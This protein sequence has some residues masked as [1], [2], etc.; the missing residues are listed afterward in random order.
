MIVRYVIAR[1]GDSILLATRILHRLCNDNS[2]AKATTRITKTYVKR[3]RPSA[4]PHR[5]RYHRHPKRRNANSPSK[6]RRRTNHSRARRFRRTLRYGISPPLL[7]VFIQ[8]RQVMFLKPRHLYQH[9]GK[10]HGSS[11]YVYRVPNGRIFSLKGPSFPLLGPR[12]PT[13][14]Q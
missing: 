4:C 1:N 3:R 8:V 10:S 11:L 14:Q 5:R 7:G 12:Q 9:V 13:R 2:H 6:P